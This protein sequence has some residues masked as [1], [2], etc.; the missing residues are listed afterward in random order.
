MRT[1][2]MVPVEGVEP[3]LP[4]GNAILSRARLPVPPHR[5]SS[6]YL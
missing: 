2:K 4:Y 5:R 3:T 6:L 1:K